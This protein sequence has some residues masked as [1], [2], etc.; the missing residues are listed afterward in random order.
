MEARGPCG[1]EVLVKDAEAGAL[2]PGPYDRDATRI[3]DI[4]G[5]KS[6]T[7]RAFGGFA[8]G[9]RWS[10]LYPRHR[11]L[12]E[13]RYVGQSHAERRRVETPRTTQ[14]GHRHH[15]GEQSRA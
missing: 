9:E 10:T 8:V 5:T 12:A 1:A 15:V 4:L 3:P 2:P 6:P 7:Q 14:T 11:E 13:E